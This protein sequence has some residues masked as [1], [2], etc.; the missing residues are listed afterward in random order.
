MQ[1]AGIAGLQSRYRPRAA[2]AALSEATLGAPSEGASFGWRRP[3]K[4]PGTALPSE[5]EGSCVGA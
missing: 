3:L 5:A 4:G 2:G 1:D